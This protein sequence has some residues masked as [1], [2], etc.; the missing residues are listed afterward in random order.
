[1]ADTSTTE[2]APSVDTSTT[3]TSSVNTKTTET[4]S[5]DTSTTEIAPE[6]KRGDTSTSL[7][8][9]SAMRDVFFN[10]GEGI[11]SVASDAAN[12]INNIGKSLSF[13]E[14]ISSIV[15]NRKRFSGKEGSG[16]KFL[17]NEYSK[18]PAVI[19]Q[20]ASSISP[21][22]SL[23]LSPSNPG[24]LRTVSELGAVA[25]TK[26]PSV[27]VAP[28]MGKVIDMTSSKDGLDFIKSENERTRDNE[29]ED[30]RNEQ[31]GI[32]N[33]TLKE[34]SSSE[35]KKDEL[36]GNVIKILNDKLDFSFMEE[37]GNGS[38]SLLDEV[39]DLFDREGK[40]KG[41]SKKNVKGRGASRTKGGV[42]KGRASLPKGRMPS[43][44]GSVAKSAG[45]FGLGR[46]G[47][48]GLGGM[49][50]AV[51]AT[52]G[53]LA[54]GYILGETIN[55]ANRY[56]GMSPEER[57]EELEKT[58]QGLLQGASGMGTGVDQDFSYDTDPYIVNKRRQAAI[59][60]SRG[61]TDITSGVDTSTGSRG[62][63]ENIGSSAQGLLTGI[64]ERSN[65]SNAPLPKSDTQA[66]VSIMPSTATVKVNPTI[67]P[68]TVSPLN[69]K[70]QTSTSAI[71]APTT[72]LQQQM[73]LAE[74]NKSLGE[75][76]KSDNAKFE[77]LT[78]K[79]PQNN[80]EIIDEGEIQRQQLASLRG[81][82]GLLT[83]IVSKNRLDEIENSPTMGVGSQSPT[84]SGMSGAAMSSESPSGLPSGETI[85]IST[86]SGSLGGGVG[87]SGPM[88]E[89]GDPNM[90]TGGGM[91][92]SSANPTVQGYLSV[93]QKNAQGSVYSQPNRQGRN[94]YDCSSFVSRSLQEA[95][96][97]ISPNNT[98][99]TLSSALRKIGFSYT[100]MPIPSGLSKAPAQL[101]AGD[102]LLNP[103]HHVETYAGNNQI[104]GAHSTNSGVSLKSFYSTGYPGFWRL[105]GGGISPNTGSS[106]PTS[107]GAM[108]GGTG[109]M[110]STPSPSGGGLPTGS[111]V[112]MS[113]G[114]G[115]T[116]TTMPSGIGEPG[117]STGMS[118]AA[119]SPNSP[120]GTPSGTG[121]QAT[122][123]ANFGALLSKYETGGKG[124]SQI[125][126][127]KGDSGGASYGKYQLSY[128]K[129][130]L[131]EYMSTLQQTNPQAYAQLAPLWGSA[132]QGKNGAF[133][134]KWQQLANQ[135]AL[136]GAEEQ[137]ARKNYMQGGMRRLKDKALVQRINANPALQEVFLST[138]VQHGA[139]GG[140]NIWNRAVNSGMTDEQ[141]IQ[142][143]YAERGRRNANGSLVHFSKN[144]AN[145]QRGVANRF[146]N[147]VKDAL[148]L[149]AQFK[150]GNYTGQVQGGT[151]SNAGGGIDPN[152]GIYNQNNQQQGSGEGMIEPV[153]GGGS[154]AAPSAGGG[155]S[156]S[157]IPSFIN[158]ITL[159]A[160]QTQLME[161]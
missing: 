156:G 125:T 113:G 88:G 155:G 133:G 117:A 27:S 126:L 37:Q 48:L 97:D 127:S 33:N 135:G 136:Q 46:L 71:N 25:S 81:I 102:I 10:L 122:N 149:N 84:S 74:V 161:G 73:I 19:P 104:V 140:S 68:L 11:T 67:K 72:S 23:S 152:V 150:S 146:N 158:D 45:R 128:T 26:T 112:G 107:T 50:T 132:G 44:G 15:G 5:V 99:S 141:I 157:T 64:I 30:K 145:I 6:N 86:G 83:Q 147:E 87:M 65:Q 160:L 91:S 92:G 109:G 54:G 79:I 14:N 69:R 66:S 20:S 106:A 28:S 80:L 93:M 35:K 103:G 53:M 89:P 34:I 154:V 76:Q 78:R 8:A 31:L 59:Q 137:Y 51:A 77:Q 143:V 17:A 61:V 131:K 139:G 108:A 4:A 21:S 24:F 49:G 134:Q 100:P 124:T 95:G 148:A 144:S 32:I 41:S 1:M 138:T 52:G 119:M 38:G 82:E 105:G 18:M 12:K 111:P 36:L 115:G 121:M 70:S 118:G 22:Y 40:E 43:V 153:G 159:M 3:E 62:I 7:I 47:G 123:G 39:S 75:I 98:T 9:L 57:K 151:V 29:A 56:D 42:P 55:W 94:S 114:I 142:A 63:S 2:T 60:A 85:P 129:G 101:Q 96:F 58:Q 13:T 116:G 90:Q 120:S 110:G 16:L 130:S